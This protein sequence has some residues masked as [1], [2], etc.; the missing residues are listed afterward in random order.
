MSSPRIYQLNGDEG[1]FVCLRPADGGQWDI[2]RRFDGRQSFLQAWIEVQVRYVTEHLH[3]D[4]GIIGDF[5]SIGFAGVPVLSARARNALEDLIAPCGEFLPLDAAGTRYWAFN[6]TCVRDVLDRKRSSVKY[7]PDSERVMYVTK[8][9]LRSEAVQ[10][11]NIFKVPEAPL[12]F[13]FVSELLKDR[14]QAV[15]LT[16]MK[17]RPVEISACH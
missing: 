11:A 14:V 8:V 5:P 12:G 17:F 16:E 1:D 9:V 4:R 2:F 3:G 10:G 7:F 6:V 13:V 15:G